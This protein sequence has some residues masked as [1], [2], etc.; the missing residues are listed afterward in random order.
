MTDPLGQ[1]QVLPYI[2]LLSK[3][4]YNFHLV[5]FE[6]TD[7]YS[8]YH[9]LIEKICLY[10]KIQWYPLKYNKKPP[11][12]STFFDLY[13]MMKLSKE[14]H[15]KNGFSLIHCRSYISSLVGLR[16]KR[17]FGI[18]FLFDMRGFWADERVEGDLWNL[19]NPFY[20]LVYYY[21][22]RDL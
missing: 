18:P 13:K 7:R 9:L 11:L 19:K 10:N 2:I 4:N 8:K 6:K 20:K 12:L 16:F 21:F 5:S 1:S 22:K 17:L 15:I 3:K 14:L